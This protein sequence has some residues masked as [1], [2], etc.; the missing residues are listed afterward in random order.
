MWSN[1]TSKRFTGGSNW[2]GGQAAA[3]FTLRLPLTMAIVDAM[4]LRVGRE[5]YLLPTVAIQRSFRPT[6]EVV[7]TITGRE[8]IIMHHDRLYPLVR[9]GELFEIEQAAVEPERAMVI[10]IEGGTK[11]CALMVDELLGQQQ[12]VIKSLGGKLANVPGVSGEAILGDGHVGLILDAA[13][14]LQIA[15]HLAKQTQANMN[16][17]PAL[18]GAIPAVPRA[19]RSEP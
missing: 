7:S 18:A 1:A 9:L 16:R 4:L 19:L 3:K 15:Q 10:L 2:T 11:R 8:E 13:G 14:L 6:R 5:Q 17:G 12:V